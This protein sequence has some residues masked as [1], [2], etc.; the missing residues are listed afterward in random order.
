MNLSTTRAITN[1]G[2]RANGTIASSRLRNSGANKPVDRLAVV[3]FARRLMEAEGCASEILRAGVGGHDQDHV[4]EVDRLAGVVG[5]L[6][7]VHDLQAG[8]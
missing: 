4:A 1:S 7:V 3:A 6:A 2:R 8:C 5:Q